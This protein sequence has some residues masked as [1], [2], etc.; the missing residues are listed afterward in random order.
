MKDWSRLPT[1]ILE[2]IFKTVRKEHV[3]HCFITC[4]AWNK[5]AE[6]VLYSEVKLLSEAQAQG[7]IKKLE[8]SKNPLEKWTK[9]LE[10]RFYDP[11]R[12]EDD[13]YQH[14]TYLASFGKY[15]Q[16]SRTYALVNRIMLSI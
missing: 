16:M 7:P 6:R 8:T 12:P 2:N 13:F 3:F 10:Y 9:T 15:F 5:A 11:S 4:K 14:D 1:E